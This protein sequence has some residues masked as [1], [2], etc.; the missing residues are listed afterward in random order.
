M[1]LVETGSFE[2]GSETGAANE[3]PVHGVNIT[4]PFYIGRYEVTFDEYDLFCDGTVGIRRPSDN[5]WGRGNRPA[6]NV[7]W[8][9]AVAYCNWLSGQHGLTPCYD[10][11]GKNVMW[12]RSCDGYRLPTEAEWE[13]AARGGS[14]SQGYTYAGGDDPDRVAWYADPG[15]ASHPVGEKLP[16]E[17]G[18]YDMS[19][20]IWEWC[21]DR[22][23]GT[24]YARSPENNPAGPRSGDGDIYFGPERSRRG[25]CFKE[26]ADVLRTTY[27]SFD[28]S[29][30]IGN[31]SG[32]RLVR[33]ADSGE[34][35]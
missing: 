31:S 32:F 26:A 3:Q 30:Y 13:Y 2:M 8:Y 12:D 19:G 18:L 28:S 6:T 27:R 16:N 20:N 1:V 21:W 35:P 25:G 7:T 14:L 17:L 24:Y 33:T 11:V 10:Q 9:D 34:E 29:A 22:Y 23:D 5:G 15:G 4:R